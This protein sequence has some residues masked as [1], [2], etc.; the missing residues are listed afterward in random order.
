MKICV[1][2]MEFSTMSTN[3][4]LRLFLGASTEVQQ[5]DNKIYWGVEKY[6]LLDYE[7][8]THF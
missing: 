5:S 3:S 7:V 8:G 1:F 4:Y 6:E 2:L